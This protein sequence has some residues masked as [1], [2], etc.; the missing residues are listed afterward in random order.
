MLK[1]IIHPTTGRIITFGRA[2]SAENPS[3]LR[4]ES[5]IN[6]S[7]LPAAPIRFDWAKPALNKDALENVEANDQYGCCTC[8]AV[9]HIQAQI[10]ANSGNPSKPM[11]PAE[12]LWLYSK[13]TSP[14]FD[15]ATGANDNGADMQTVL[16]FWKTNGCRQDGSGK[17]LGY[18]ALDPTKPD[19]I[20]SC[21]W[22]FE[23]GYRGTA[24]PDAWLPSQESDPSVWDIA[25]PADPQ[26]G[27]C[28]ES[29]GYNLQGAFDDSWGEFKTVTWRATAE[30]NSSAAGG[31]YYVVLSESAI[32]KATKK[33]PTG[34]DLEQLQAYLAAA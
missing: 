2:R 7:T 17:I 26:N 14:P 30:Y 21:L 33:A 6:L 29:Y 23:N 32:N 12:T 20:A 11:T 4:A 8:S 22:L 25:G 10:E 16:D 13:V 34:F 19:L 18:M 24:L 31:E 1:R 15:P 28:T 5:V 9:A 3:I 27:H